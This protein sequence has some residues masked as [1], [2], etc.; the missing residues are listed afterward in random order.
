MIPCRRVGDR[1]LLEGTYC[2]HL[3]GI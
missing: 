1:H 2:L 3:Q